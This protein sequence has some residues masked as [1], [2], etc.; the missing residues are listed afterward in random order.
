VLSVAAEVR[1]S[2]EFEISATVAGIF[3]TDGSGKMVIF[4]ANGVSHEVE[5]PAAATGIEVKVPNGGEVAVGLPVAQAQFTSFALVAPILGADLLRFT[6]SPVSARAQINAS[7]EPFDCAFID[8]Y[9]T[10]DQ[11]AQSGSF[12]ACAVP[13]D[14]K[15]IVGLSGLVAFRFPGKTQVLSLPIEAVAGSRDSGSVYRT[16]GSSEKSETK[17]GLGITDGIR[18]EVTTGL[19][20]GDTVS[21]PNPGLL[22]G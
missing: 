20:E 7:G 10:K 6:T 9:P 17:I 19:E 15:V 22:G 18:I 8:S 21:L 16:G 11:T 12:M 1:S 14:Q 5:V 13:N 2:F 3:Q 4:D